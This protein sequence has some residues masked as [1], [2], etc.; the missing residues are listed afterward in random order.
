MKF[1]QQATP[2]EFRASGFAPGTTIGRAGALAQASSP[3]R[4]THKTE[5]PLFPAIKPRD[6]G[7]T[8]TRGARTG[9][10]GCSAQPPPD[11]IPRQPLGPTYA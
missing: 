2:W 4:G 6:P 8:S 9:V 7:L 1:A 10:P 3:P 11:R 5:Q